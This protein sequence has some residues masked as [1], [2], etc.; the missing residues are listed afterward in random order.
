MSEHNSATLSTL[1]IHDEQNLGEL[2]SL[3]LPFLGYTT[4]RK[5]LR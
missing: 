4:G 5:C 3:F 1:V 2:V